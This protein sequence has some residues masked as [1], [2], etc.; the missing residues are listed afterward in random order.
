MRVAAIMVATLLI[1]A[2]LP[3][4]QIAVGQGVG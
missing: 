1:A 2:M 3:L 4:D